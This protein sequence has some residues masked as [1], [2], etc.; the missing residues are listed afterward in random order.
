[1]V[2]FVAGLAT[3]VV[4]VILTLVLLFVAAVRSR[5]KPPQV[6]S[7]SVLV[8][9]PSGDIPEK[10]P[11]DL[12]LFSSGY[13]VTV[14]DVWMALHKA[15]ADSRIKAVVF[16]PDGLT[17][18]WGKMEELRADLEQFRKSGKPVFA[19]L[20][21]PNTA[22]YYISL[23]ADRIY[24]GPQEPLYLKGLRAEIPY[25][26]K[27]LAKLGVQV[28]VEHAGKYKDFGDMFTRMDMSPETRQVTDSIVND[29][30][31]NL[32]ARI[33]VAR[34][35]TPEEVRAL[36]DQGPFTATGALQAGLVDEL[37]FE[38]QM[39]GELT[40]RLHSGKPNRVTIE[41]Y[42]KVPAESVGLGGNAHVAVVVAQGDI[43]RGNPDDDGSESSLT[44]YGFDKMLN[45]VANDSSIKAI[46]V[47]IDSPGGD[48]AASDEM[49]RQMNLAAQK[50]PMVISMGDVAAS[51]GYFM[52]MN[53]APIVAYSATETGSIGVVFGKPIIRGLLDK[54]GVNFDA[55]Q[56]GRNADI[57][58]LETPLTPDQ[59][60]LLRRGIDESYRDFVTKVANARHRSY[61]RINDVAQGR[62]WLGSQAVPHGL[63][64]E[65]GDLDTAVAVLKKKAGIPAS[66]NVSFVTYPA[67]RSLLDMLLK[68]SQEESLIDIKLR[69]VFGKIPFHAWMGG[70]MLRIMPNWIEVQ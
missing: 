3:G 28:E 53:G 12:S 19:Y 46:L 42:A 38:D 52:A 7:D 30:Y 25:F 34:K 55:V 5:Q 48:A 60:D 21:G 27:L 22:E 17:I 33:A 45:R 61:D 63:V 59:L 58:S 43:L 26:Q 65:L 2:K 39:W 18:D 10:P 41:D 62:V 66:E 9:R 8:L 11:L 20:R 35:K 69:P 37:R 47:R 6:A 70:G 23:A 50:K 15:A 56:R 49:W 57:E 1:M 64:D 51:G 68:R 31:G 24:L 13:A 67:R 29:L 32:V 40:T 16:A 14:A 54:I 36:I 4:L 44:S